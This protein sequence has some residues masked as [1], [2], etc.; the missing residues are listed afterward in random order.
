MEAD[1]AAALFC[2]GQRRALHL[3]LITG[4]KSSLDALPPGTAVKRVVKT[5]VGVGSAGISTQL[6]VA[7]DDRAGKAAR[8]R[9]S[10]SARR[11]RNGRPGLGARGARDTCGR[12]HL[13]VRVDLDVRALALLQ[14]VVQ[15]EQVVPGDQDAR[16]RLG[17]FAHR[18]GEGAGRT[19]RRALR[20][21]SP[22]T[23]RFCGRIPT[24]LQQRRDVEVHVGHGREQGFLDEGADLLIAFCRGGGRGWRRRPCPHSTLPYSEVRIVDSTDP[25]NFEKAIDDKTRLLFTESIGN[26]KGNIDDFPAIAAI[27][28][29]HGIP[30]VVD[31]TVSPPPLFNPFEHGADVAVYSLTKMIGGHGTSIGGAVIEKGDFDWKS[32]GKFPE[33]TDP[34]PSYHGVI[35]WDAFG[36]H[37][38][39]VAPGLAY[40][41]KI[42]T[43]L[44]RDTGAALSP[45]NVQQFLLG[46]ETLPL[47]ARQHVSNAQKVAEFLSKHPAVTWVNFPGLPSH[48][49][50][51]RGKELMPV[52]AGAVLGFGIK[53]GIEA[54]RKFI[55]SVKL[56]SHLANILDAKTLVI[57]PASTTH[58]QLT[59]S[60]Q[61]AAGVTSDFV[62]VSVGL[63]NVEDI[64][65]D[66]SQALD[67]SQK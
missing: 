50:Y 2:L 4:E 37:P 65:A 57:H 17:A 47:R 33:I 36:N 54:G 24:H 60:E 18:G 22:S 14:Q 28:H 62:R 56:C 21:A 45:F 7:S 58:Q 25:K 30:L 42:R 8:T 40:V 20:P 1:G 11:R 51:K 52:G 53:G 66:L 13:A 10:A 44:L 63:E 49:D 3:A 31:N 35:F 34:D 48:P 64:V 38:K 32:K 23:R 12:Q 59:A 41:L 26:P 43:G 61:E 39:A 67:V 5:P 19:S 6:V 16:A 46:L 29:K 27:A 9:S 15:V 55:N